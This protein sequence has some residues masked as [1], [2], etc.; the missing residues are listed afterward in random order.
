MK[1]IKTNLLTGEITEVEVVETESTTEQLNQIR[2][3]NLLL[4]LAELDAVMP[5]YIEDMVIAHNDIETANYPA[6]FKERFY[7][8]QALRNELM[9]L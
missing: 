9:A 2:K 3:S 1:V 6:I 7:R 5:R 8:K 4:E